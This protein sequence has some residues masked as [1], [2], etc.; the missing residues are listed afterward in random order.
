MCGE[1]PGP[2]CSGASAELVQAVK[3]AMA[4]FCPCCLSVQ[5]P[6][7]SVALPGRLL[8]SSSEAL[9]PCQAPGP[10]E[11]SSANMEPC[12]DSSALSLSLG[13]FPVA[14]GGLSISPQLQRVFIKLSEKAVQKNTAIQAV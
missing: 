7:L 13:I 9:L 3:A 4:E 11:K 2:G 6:S 1:S 5:G 14:G 8:N 12:T 10:W